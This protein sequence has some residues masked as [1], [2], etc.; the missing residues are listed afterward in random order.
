MTVGNVRCSQNRSVAAV[1]GA[2]RRQTSAVRSITAV[3]RDDREGLSFAKNG[4][5]LAVGFPVC[6]ALEIVESAAQGASLK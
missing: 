6:S 5:N 4:H 1:R 2:W 3:R